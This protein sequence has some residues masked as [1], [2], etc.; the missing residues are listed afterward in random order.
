LQDADPVEG[1]ELVAAVA[2]FLSNVVRFFS[3]VYLDFMHSS[4]DMTAAHLSLRVR[5]LGLLCACTCHAEFKRK[6]TM[7][8]ASQNVTS[9]GNVAGGGR[10]EYVRRGRHEGGACICL[11][12]HNPCLLLHVR[13]KVTP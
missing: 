10:R 11:F 1:D 2:H 8:F 13:C 6:E 4:L 12:D 9:L 3:F 5:T 7:Y